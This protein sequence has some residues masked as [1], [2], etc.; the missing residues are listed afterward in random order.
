MQTYI[1]DTPFTSPYRMATDTSLPPPV[2]ITQQALNVI[3]QLLSSQG[4]MTNKETFIAD[5]YV[6]GQLLAQ[7]L[8]PIDI[9]WVRTAEELSKLA[10]DEQKAYLKL[11]KEWGEKPITLDLSGSERDC[12]VRAFRHNAKVLLEAGKLGFNPVL[13]E[14][15]KAF[16]IRD[17][18]EKA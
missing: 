6:T 2:T 8:P 14:I 13:F 18:P 12:I 1:L 4:W 17:T 7:T 3:R 9:S 5:M 16:D 15:V 11:D 10:L